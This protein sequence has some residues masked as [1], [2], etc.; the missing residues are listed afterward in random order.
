MRE[1]QAGRTGGF[2]I[3]YEAAVGIAVLAVL[4]VISHHNYLLFH[5]IAEVF[6]SV[7]AFMIF[8][9]AWHT[10]RLTDNDFLLFLGIAYLFI[11]ALD[12]MHMLAYSGMGVFEGYGTDLATQL[13]IATRYL[14]A[15]SLFLAPLFLTRKLRVK[16]D[17]AAYT[18]AAA[19]V[20][21]S[22]FYWDIFPTCFVEGA[23]LTV[24]K[25]ISEYVI[26]FILLLAVGALFR[27]RE[28]FDPGV[29]KLIVASI[30]VTIASE[31]SFT[32][33]ADP[34]GFFNL[35]GHYLKIISFY[36]IY[37]AIV[38]T[39]L[40][41]PYDI[42][43]RELK[44]REEQLS[45]R[46]VRER[47][48]INAT[49]DSLYLLKPDGT[50]LVCNEVA[51][52]G[53]GRK[54][55]EL[56]DAD[57][58]DFLPPRVAAGRKE[59]M[60]RCLREGE[61][62]QFEEEFEGTFLDVAVYP[63]IGQEGKIEMMAVFARDITGRKRAEE[64]ILASRDRWERTFDAVREGL[65]IMDENRTIL[66]CNSAFAEIV[67]EETQ[68]LTGRK[69]YQ[70]VHGT[71]DLPAACIACRTFEGGGEVKSEI[72]EP[73]LDKHLEMLTSPIP[74]AEGEP[75]SIIHVIRDITER[76]RAEEQ[77]EHFARELQERVRELNCLYGISRIMEK[78]GLSLEDILLDVVEIIPPSWQYPEITC[79]R[80][81]LGDKVFETGDFRETPWRLARDVSVYGEK[82]GVL[83][84]C[85]LEE[86]PDA[87]TGPFLKEEE[88]LLR[89]VAEHLGRI[90]ERKESERE[91]SSYRGRLEDLVDERTQELQ[92]INM[93]LQREISEREREQR[94]L[95]IRTGQLRALSMRMESMVEDE[96]KRMAR[97]VHDRLGQELTGLKMDLLFL[98][99]K[100]AG[101]EEYAARIREISE[102]TDSIIQTVQEISM[103]LRPSILD[104]L[105]LAAALEWQLD[106]FGKAANI[107][108]RFS[109]S[110]ED[111]HIDPD[112]GTALF[113]IFQEALIN[114]A[115]HAAAGEV[116][117]KL[118]QEGGELILVVSDD[119]RGIKE[120]EKRSVS[121][122]GLLGMRER[123]HTF[124]GRVDISGREKGGTT[125]KVS[126]PLAEVG[127]SRIG[128]E[129]LED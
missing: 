20:L 15:L 17:L 85:Y 108:T 90:I 59:A 116:E 114:V 8:I 27:K 79:A 35:M 13:W 23:G 107:I 1:N 70:V 104:D 68:D 102:S 78:A 54:V 94:E 81:T 6:S 95:K 113:R 45:E 60:D 11:G 124:G 7:V 33:Y 44:S 58:F 5:G 56:L 98:E 110:V 4:Y 89:A 106:S 38:E 128:G 26:S 126:V 16:L 39:G 122:L 105:G 18:A 51:A 52:G 80:V 50:V 14:E 55:E 61:A 127:E 41:R 65:F 99:R 57:I 93:R 83:E 69:C 129:E 49:G 75:R 10:R 37:R 103:E 115:R 28:K 34:Y 53:L 119:G 48:M 29:F 121:S 87:D 9:L 21:L 82:A 118:S 22:I 86:R 72:Y 25:R 24:F 12:L 117:V 64:E 36:L 66:R 74:G 3:C 125:V 77:L 42:L 123:A 112:L 76:K 30:A 67:G 71:Q 40:E 63:V 97:E 91:L 62:V 120:S 88:D 43:F 46:E 19:L 96:R 84:V 31:L 47:A 101:E 100:M 32:L 2:R 73:S 92:E 111:D 109:S